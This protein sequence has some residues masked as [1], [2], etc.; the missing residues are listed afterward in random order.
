MPFDRLSLGG[1]LAS[2][3]SDFPTAKAGYGVT[4]S[5]YENYGLDASFALNEGVSIFGTYLNETFDLDQQSRYGAPPTILPDVDSWRTETR[6][7][8]ETYQVGINARVSKKLD[9]Q[10]DYTLSDG[11]SQV[12]CI[13]APG[14]NASGNCAF[15][16][17]PTPVVQPGWPDVKSKLTWFKA[18]GS[19]AITPRFGVGLE[20]WNYQFDGEDWAT[21]PLDVY[22]GD[23]LNPANQLG[24]NNSVFVNGKVPDY[25]ADIYRVY[26][27][28]TF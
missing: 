4:A 3:D 23:V 20:F 15:P 28:Y 27:D 26:V 24:L 8:T 25:D 17:S 10:F 1:S 18:R 14:G 2:W 9:F 21:D 5:T 22:V 16:T 11:V 19:Y 13:A 7:E 12:A 6:D